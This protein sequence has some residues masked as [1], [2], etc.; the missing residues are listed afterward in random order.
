MRPDIRISH[1]K[2]G[3]IKDF[4]AERGLSTSEAYELI[5]DAG[6]EALVDEP[7]AIDWE[8]LADEHD[9]DDDQ[10]AAA[11]AVVDYCGTGGATKDDILD[12]VYPDHAGDAS[13]D[14][15]WRSVVNE[16][17]EEADVVESLNAKVVRV[18]D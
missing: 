10:L 12:D 9:L 7:P 11:Q 6:L 8:R 18:R 2:N 17:L 13:R 16:V 14:W 5:I 3:R 4:A 15:W 1:T